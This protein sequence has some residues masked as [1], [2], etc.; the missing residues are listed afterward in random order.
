MSGAEGFRSTPAPMLGEHSD[1]ICRDLL[2]MS[3]SEIKQLLD[4]DIL[5]NP[6]N[7]ESTGA[8]MFG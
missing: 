3:D 8:S 2:G 5:H 4:Q 6:S 7:T 1:E